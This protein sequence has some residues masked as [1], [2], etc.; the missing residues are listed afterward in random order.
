MNT[1][2][3]FRALVLG[4]FSVLLLPCA[5]VLAQTSATTS[6][7]GFTQLPC[8]A[9]SDT[10]ISIPFTQPAAFEGAIG[11]ISGNTITVASTP[12]WTTN[13]FVY[14]SGVQSNTYY[15]IVGPDPV[16]I[17]GAVSVTNGSTT[18][19]GSGFTPIA[20]GDEIIVNG[21][22][23]NVAAVASDT[24]LTISRAFTGTTASGLAATY[25]HSPK[26]GCYYTVTA[27]GSNTLTVNLNGD[28]L[29]AVAAGTSVTLIPY[30]TLG[31][32][33]PSGNAGTSF[34]ASTGTTP[35]TR[36]T[37]VLFP[38][39]TDT[40]INLAPTSAYYYYNGAWRLASSD[41][42]VSYNDVVLPPSTYF[43]VRNVATGTTFTPAGGVYMDRITLPLDTSSSGQ[44]NAVAV[45]RPI[46]VAFNDLGL[47]TSGAFVASTG[48]T[49]R[50][51]GDTL[52]V[53][54]NTQ[55]GINKA[56]TTS[57]Y[58]YNS[59]WR[60]VSSDG[61]TDY[62]ATTNP[63]GVGFTIRKAQVASEATSFCQNTRTY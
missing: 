7:V 24:S 36:Q 57:Y 26:E 59:G 53:Y 49:N 44:D 39:L 16:V 8:L 11:S 12:N 50:T 15:A 29:G 46:A 37:Q 17:S 2:L 10:L 40:G 25:D 47:I 55:P 58:Y 54:D 45:A 18:V 61:T 51:R 23:Y 28:S 41:G 56:P 34:I 20:V 48:T 6:P 62:G 9:N 33:F 43:I 30:W 31:L 13:Q 5:G 63:Y 19:T 4:A 1:P 22:A 32:A 14:S 60:L 52:L 35:R 42:T 3:S 21:L 27:N 38:D